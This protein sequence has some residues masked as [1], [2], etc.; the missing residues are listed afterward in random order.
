MGSCLLQLYQLKSHGPET[1]FLQ[2]SRICDIYSSLAS[3]A[4]QVTLP[5]SPRLE[6]T[7]KNRHYQ[8]RS[9]P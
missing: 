9:L 1:G 6:E 7:T 8:P 2:F 3:L 4:L 5:E